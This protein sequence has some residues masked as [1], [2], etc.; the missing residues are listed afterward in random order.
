MHLQCFLSSFVQFS[1]S[2]PSFSHGAL[3]V[4][5]TPIIDGTYYGMALPIHLSLSIRLSSLYKLY[6]RQ[7]PMKLC[8][9]VKNQN[10][11]NKFG[12]RRRYPHVKVTVA[13]NRILLIVY[14]MY[15]PTPK[16]CGHIALFMSVCPYVSPEFLC[17]AFI[18]LV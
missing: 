1:W 4:G 3:S 8:L 13:I 7:I 14:I 5:Y 18:F 12:F 2:F 6:F 15:I 17:C 16:Q 10:V 11:L 9:C